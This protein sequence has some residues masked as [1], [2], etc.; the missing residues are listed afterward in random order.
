MKIGVK[1][2][3][4][5]SGCLI[6]L[7]VST[8]ACICPPQ[9]P[10]PTPPWCESKQVVEAGKPTKATLWVTV[11]Y[12]TPQQDMIL[13]SIEG[14]SPIKMNKVGTLSWETEI[15]VKDGDILTYKYLKGS[16][17]SFS[18]QY[19]VEITKENQKI[20]DGVSGWSDLPFNPDFPDNFLIAINM[21]DTWGRNYNFN[22]FEDTRKNIASSFERVAETGA[23]EVY[24]HDFLRAVFGEDDRISS[25]D[26]KI[27]GGIFDDDKRDEVMTQNDLNSLAKEAKANGL[28]IGWRTNLD[29]VNWGKF[30]D[31]PNITA[32]IA[33]VFEEF[34]KPKTEEWVKDFLNK[35]KQVMLER[36]EMLNKAG[37]DIM[38]LTPFFMAPAYYPHE[39]LANEMW[40]DIVKSVSA[41][42]NGQVGIVVGGGFLEGSQYNYYREADIVYYLIWQLLDKYQTSE[43]PSL[44]EMRESFAEYLDDLEKRASDEGVKLSIIAHLYS[45]ENSLNADEPVEVSDIGNPAILNIKA[46]WQYQADAYEAL[47]QAAQG[48]ENIIGIV[49]FKYWWDDAMNPQDTKVRIDIEG[50]VRNKPAEAVIK[51]WATTL[52]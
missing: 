52:K 12:N 14:Q 50:S 48:R 6:L 29:F 11:P 18:S 36:A 26:Y 3:A 9:G 51:K 17:N 37:F 28:K 38:I 13:L 25:T 44:E 31:S 15:D 35:W 23:K 4:I 43:N 42:F 32:E 2:L 49:S 46:D 1:T 8:T 7:L 45:Y 33:K 19:E 34:G 10:W 47:F 39:E 41:V 24:V 27:E 22:W 21:M 5:I 40:Q 30:I 16:E 20:Y